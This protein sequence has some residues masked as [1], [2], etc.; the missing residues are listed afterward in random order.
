MAPDELITLYKKGTYVRAFELSQLYVM[1][2]NEKTQSRVG[3]EERVD[4]GKGG[5]EG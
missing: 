4:M 3:R 2:K 5:G 1:R